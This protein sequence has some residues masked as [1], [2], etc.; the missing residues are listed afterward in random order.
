[1]HSSQV[2]QLQWLPRSLVTLD[3]QKAMKTIVDKPLSGCLTF[4]NRQIF[5]IMVLASSGVKHLMVQVT[6]CPGGPGLQ[7]CTQHAQR[8]APR[9]CSATAVAV[10]CSVQPTWVGRFLCASHAQCA[11][12]EFAFKLCTMCPPG[13]CHDGFPPKCR[14]AGKTARP[15]GASGGGGGGAGG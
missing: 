4:L 3:R 11:S 5:Q 10:D 1:M 7:P 2:V 8:P 12:N 9:I 13:T 14:I 6:V 15:S